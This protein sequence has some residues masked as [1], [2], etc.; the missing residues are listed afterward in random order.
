MSIE[1]VRAGGREG[2]GGGSTWRCARACVCVGGVGCCLFLGKL[3]KIFPM[4]PLYLAFPSL[5]CASACRIRST[6][7]RSFVPPLT[8]FDPICALSASLLS[9]C[10]LEHLQ[11]FIEQK[12]GPVILNIISDKDT[13]LS[14]GYGFATFATEG[15]AQQCMGATNIDYEG[16][17]L[18]FG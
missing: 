8:H 17:N 16:R 15:Q 11:D 1:R 2:R 18:N 3:C 10:V 5:L 9:K 7:A 4:I 12:F 13:Q 6:R 14:K